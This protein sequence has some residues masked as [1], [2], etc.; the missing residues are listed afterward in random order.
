VHRRVLP[1][2][3]LAFAATAAAGGVA[4]NRLLDRPGESALAFVPANALAA[5]SLDLVPAPD[6]VLAFKSINEM[7]SSAADKEPQAKAAKG[8]EHDLAHPEAASPS[9]GGRRICSPE[10]VE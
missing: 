7:I 5:I 9:A 3:F 1:Y 10:A 2:A 6:Q 8:D 4:L